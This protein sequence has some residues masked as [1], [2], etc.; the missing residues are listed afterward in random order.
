MKEAG[1]KMQKKKIV[2]PEEASSGSDETTSS[3]RSDSDGDEAEASPP[4]K[5]A[6]PAAARERKRSL[7]LG[8]KKALQRASWRRLLGLGWSCLLSLSLFYC[9]LLFLVSRC[10]FQSHCYVVNQLKHTS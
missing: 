9:F 4:P 5:R 2:E 3:E 10:L 6:N 7:R 8:R 1:R